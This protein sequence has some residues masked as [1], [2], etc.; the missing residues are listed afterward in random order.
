M[1]P[2]LSLCTLGL[3]AGLC[4]APLAQAQHFDNFESWTASAGGTTLNVTPKAA[5]KYYNPVPASSVS[6]NVHTYA[7]NTLSVAANP[8]GGS[9][10][11][12]G[13]G[14][15]RVNNVLTF[16][17]SQ[18]DVT[19]P[20]KCDTV[21]VGFDILALTSAATPANN[22]GSFSLQRFPG[23]RS[24]IYLATWANTTTK[25]WQCRIIYYT[26][27]G[28]RS[29][30]V[31]VPGTGFTNLPLNKWYR[32]EVDYSISKNQLLQIRLTDIA[33]G[34]TVKYNPPSATTAGW[35]LEGGSNPGT[36]P[37]PTGYRLFGGSSV[38]GNTLAF[39]NVSVGAALVASYGA[40]PGRP[41]VRGSLIVTGTPT[42]GST[43]TLAV[44]N[45]VE[46]SKIN[47]GRTGG[48]TLLVIALA[49]L[50]PGPKFAG[51]GMASQGAVGELL[52]DPR[53]F[54]AVFGLSP[55]DGKS[56][57]S[58]LRTSIPAGCNLVGITAYLQGI[59][60][61]RG[62]TTAALTEG[63]ELRVGNR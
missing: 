22:L 15:G 12:A 42:I 23:D 61:D 4:L 32:W 3:V 40:G 44:H 21:T 63:I 57:T 51:F 56:T 59:I 52:I 8:R 38:A 20:T 50:D 53:F 46:A 25:V 26:S 10:F 47:P 62:K 49:K 1:T 58:T 18:I 35:F 34:A 54:V 36:L 2:H 9:N 48:T 6:F 28:T 29:G 16:A 13:T 27:T 33:K 24:F 5:G 43:L 41:N 14:P 37:A 39:D 55:W 7:N 60:G 31:L 19:Y 30:S 17:R 45:P 11:A